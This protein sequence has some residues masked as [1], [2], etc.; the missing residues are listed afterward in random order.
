MTAKTEIVK[1]LGEQAVLIPSLIAE[2]LSA[3]DRVKLRL[4]MLQ[5]AAAAAAG[6]PVHTLEAEKRA[7]GLSDLQ[8]EQTVAGA[9]AIGDG[10][11]A[12]P[13]VSVLIAGIPSDI[14]TMLAPIEAM[15]PETARC[16]SARFDALRA[17]IPTAEGDVIR[18]ADIARLTAAGAHE[19]DSLHQLI[20]EAHKAINRIAVQT[21]VE[22]IEGAHVYHLD[23]DDK[24]L[25]TNFMRGLNRTAFLAFGH[26]GLATT[27]AHIGAKLTIQ[28]DIGATDAHVIVIHVD[29]LAVSITYTDVHLARAKFFAS[30]FALWDAEWSA[31]T[32]QEAGGLGQEQ[33]FYLMNGRFKASSREELC[34]FLTFLGSRIVFLID[35]NKARKA[36]QTFIGRKAAVDLLVWA[37]EEELGHRAFIELGG[38]EL[39][40]DAIRHVAAGR[41]PYGARLDA[42]LGEKESVSFLRL[43]LKEASQGLRA[44]HTARLIRDQIQADLGQ[45]FESGESAVLRIVERHLGLSRDLASGIWT[46]LAHETNG[47]GRAL[48]TRRAKRIEAKADRITLAARDACTK[49]RNSKELRIVVDEVENAVDAFD[50]G[51]FLLSLLPDGETSV[52]FGDRLTAL[53]DLATR[54][55]GEMVKAVAGTARLPEGQRIDAAFA[56]QA[57]DA[58]GELERLADAAQRN[59]LAAFFTMKDIDTNVLILGIEIA[60]AI[61]RA[62]DYL[63]HAAHAL[64]DRVLQELSA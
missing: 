47:A 31:L 33:V 35:W 32:E 54:S 7:S 28:N 25:V 56:L 22:L 38:V 10:R 6:S 16:L 3:N 24:E 13:G 26:P 9:R 18:R 45:R 60:R 39:V 42:V 41:I 27:A 57:L 48:L 29:N 59:A 46:A 50:E 53:A 49:L 20:M 5:E 21:A 52:A 17:A 44:G 4:T 37:A 1:R 43:V 23:A 14:E 30:L 58:V 8:F 15:E 19:Q 36:L 63:A 64:R 51:A 62:T 12:A 55:T 40:F 61:E 2:A 34:A 11:V